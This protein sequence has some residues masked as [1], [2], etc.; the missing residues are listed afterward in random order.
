MATPVNGSLG[1]GVPKDTK[2][3]ISHS[4]NVSPRSAG[5]VVKE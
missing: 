2:R 3:C 1:I 5:S 4:Q